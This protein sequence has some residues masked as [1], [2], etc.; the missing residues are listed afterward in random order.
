MEDALPAEQPMI[1]QIKNSIATV[2]VILV[3]VPA[4]TCLHLWLTGELHG[5]A[6][7]PDALNHSSFTALMASVFW[8]FFKSPF[9]GK[10]TEILSSTTSSS[11]AQ[12]ISSV[13][14]TEPEAKP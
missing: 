5:W 7:L 9:A 10:I 12:K 14:I 6:E 8:L 4:A 3:G 13:K 2:A 11:G 1:P